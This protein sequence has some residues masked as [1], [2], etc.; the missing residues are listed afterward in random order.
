M[1]RLTFKKNKKDYSD[2][3]L[4]AGCI[5]EDRVMQ[6]LLFD[7]YSPIMLGVC[8]RY[9]HSLSEAED[10]MQEGFVKVFNCLKQFK[11]ESSLRTWMTRIMVN[12]AISYFHSNKKYNLESDL[13]AP[14]NQEEA[15]VFQFH[16]FDTEK[17]MEQIRQLPDGYRMVFNLFAIE[18]FSHKEI[19]EKLGI[20]ESSSRSQFARARQMLAK[21]INELYQDSTKAYERRSAK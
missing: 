17:L 6:N 9:V 13:S 15:V 8:H 20:A 2:T 7:R 16:G 12:T 1:L 18:G 5:T 19:G 11:G 10:V 4:I 3:E 14:A 21:K